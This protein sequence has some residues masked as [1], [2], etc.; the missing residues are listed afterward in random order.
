MPELA[1][2]AV[3]A[4]QPVAAPE[5]VAAM[6]VAAGQELV[7]Y[8]Q[9]PLPDEL[10]VQ[11]A[12]A[13]GEPLVVVPSVLREL[14][15]LGDAFAAILAAEQGDRGAPAT[16]PAPASAA[17]VPVITDDVID[18]VSRRVIEQL[19]D[20]VVREAVANAVSSVAERLVREEIERIKAAIKD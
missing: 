20:S 12:I 3:A 19:T 10:V 18:R 8:T 6:T 16:W 13:V 4:S 7:A 9:A 5:P 11:R 1:V 14:P 2:V 15:P 17:A